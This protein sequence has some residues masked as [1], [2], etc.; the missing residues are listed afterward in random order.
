M[1]DTIYRQEAIDAL[2]DNCNNVQAVCAHYPCKQY[3]AV[4]K[5]PSA[6]PEP[7]EDAVSRSDVIDML[8]MYPFT[9]YGEYESA[10]ETVKRLPSAQPEQQWIPCS[11]RLPEKNGRYLV[12]RGL[13]VCNSIWNRVYIINYS[14]LMGLKAEKIW[15]DGNVGKSD[16]QRIDDVVAWRELPEPWREESNDRT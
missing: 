6:Q 10:R 12:T 11:E 16:F 7:C 1:K 15:W 5:L 13:K 3:I 8:E 2:C 4:E 14:D 9:E